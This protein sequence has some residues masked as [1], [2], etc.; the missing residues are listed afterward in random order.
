[1]KPMKRRLLIPAALGLS[2]T[3]AACGPDDQ[4]ASADANDSWAQALLMNGS[5]GSELPPLPEALPMTADPQPASA[6]APLASALPAPSRAV[7]RKST[8]LNSSHVSESRMPS[9]A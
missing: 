9:S 7:D 4:A 1:M 8:R 6:L 3:L 2:L 5:D